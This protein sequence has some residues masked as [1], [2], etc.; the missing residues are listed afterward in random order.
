MSY[1]KT[2]YSRGIVPL[3]SSFPSLLNPEQGETAFCSEN[4]RVMTY[5]GEL[6]M[7][8]DFIKLTN[9]STRTVNAGEIMVFASTSSTTPKQATVTTLLSNPLVAGVVP[10]PS[11]NN[12][13]VA[14]AYKGIY[15]IDIQTFIVTP[16]RMGYI[17]RC[18]STT[19]G[20][21]GNA[22]ND[23][24]GNTAGWFAWTVEVPASVGLVRCLIRNKVEYA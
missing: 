9:I 6:W 16:V 1:I 20:G 17:V 22:T 13:P 15:K 5:D 7:C 19:G 11:V 21:K 23:I 3:L 18:G 12:A 10:Y 24:G 4:G 2:K 14:L 8:D